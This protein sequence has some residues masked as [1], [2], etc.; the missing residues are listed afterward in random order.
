MNTYRKFMPTM[1]NTLTLLVGVLFVWTAIQNWHTNFKLF[2]LVVTF[3]ILVLILSSAA[4]EIW[5]PKVYREG[6]P[7]WQNAPY[8]SVAC[9]IAQVLAGIAFLALISTL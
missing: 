6:A 9:F 3:A 5:N 7:F 4:Q 8:I 2:P 1:A